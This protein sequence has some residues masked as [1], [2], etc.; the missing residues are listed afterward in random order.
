M[1]RRRGVTL[2]ISTLCST[3]PGSGP[4]GSTISALDH[5]PFLELGAEIVALKELLDHARIGV[6][7]AVYADVRFRLQRNILPHQYPP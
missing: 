7:A 4:S 2:H 5:S 1:C 3:G 6:A